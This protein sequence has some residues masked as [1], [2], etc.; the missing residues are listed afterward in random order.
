MKRCCLILIILS[1]LLSACGLNGPVTVPDTKEGEKPFAADIHVPV[2]T[3]DFE[4]LA[5]TY[6]GR[7]SFAFG[8]GGTG[9]L[10]DPEKESDLQPSEPETTEQI[11]ETEAPTQPVEPE[12]TEVIPETLP[13]SSEAETTEVPEETLPEET[14]EE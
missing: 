4:T 13:T 2:R 5:D 11:P 3:A 9:Y 8:E 14:T 7:I 6:T 1:M 12:T 10:I